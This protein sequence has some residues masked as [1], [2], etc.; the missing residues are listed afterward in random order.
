MFTRPEIASLLKDQ[1]VLVD[2]YRWHRRS[3]EVNQK[4]EESK[5]NTIAIPFYVITTPIKTF[6]PPSRN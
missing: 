5:F 2:L 6:V 3:L 4:L 1:F